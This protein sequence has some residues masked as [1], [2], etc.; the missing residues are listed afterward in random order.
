MCSPRKSA[1]RGAGA[2]WR[3]VGVLLISVQGATRGAEGFAPAMTMTELVVANEQPSVLDDSAKQSDGALS[4]AAFPELGSLALAD[5]RRRLSYSQLEI[6]TASNGAEDDNFGISVA[7]A[8][9]TVVVGAAKCDTSG[10]GLA[11][12]FRT[13]NGGASYDEVDVL[14]AS[15][16]AAGDCFGHSVAIKGDTVM[17]RSASFVRT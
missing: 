13:T 4:H 6:L 10:S 5:G 14:T 3:L 12:V 8:G 1:A 17:R 7:I 15:D 16:G 9:S 11:Y 2:A